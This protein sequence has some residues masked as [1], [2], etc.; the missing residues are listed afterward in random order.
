MQSEANTD[1]V[2]LQ[3]LMFTQTMIMHNHLQIKIFVNRTFNT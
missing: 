2:N 1:G 3:L